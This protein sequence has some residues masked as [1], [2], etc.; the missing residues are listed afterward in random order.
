MRLFRPVG[1]GELRQIAAAQFLAF[2]ARSEAAAPFAPSIDLEHARQIARD[3]I[4]TDERAGFVGFVT[5]FDVSAAFMSS[6]PVQSSG[7]TCHREIWV[8]AERE[9]E[10]NAQIKGAIRIVE[11]FVGA[12]F[13]GTLPEALG[14]PLELLGQLNL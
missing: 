3:W 11:T 1:L 2:P 7:P 13:G 12:R 4:A 5:Q 14:I 8:P 6:F 9:A 10:F